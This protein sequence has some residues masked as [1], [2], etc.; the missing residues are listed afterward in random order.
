MAGKDDEFL[1]RLL[2]T[3]RGEAEELVQC[4]S[5]GVMELERGVDDERRRSLVELVYRSAHSLKGAART[6]ELTPLEMLCQ[7]FEDTLA[8]LKAGSI[9]MSAP[10]LDLLHETTDLASDILA[11]PNQGKGKASIQAMRKRLDEAANGKLDGTAAPKSE[12]PQPM[13]TR[14]PATGQTPPAPPME[15]PTPIQKPPQAAIAPR[16]EELNKPASQPPEKISSQSEGRNGRLSGQ[17]SVRISRVKL[18]KLMLQA[19]ELIALKLAVRQHGLA[20]RDI[21]AM[22]SRWKRESVRPGRG[23]TIG[24]AAGASQPPPGS[25][26]QGDASDFIGALEQRLRRLRRDFEDESRLASGMVDS[27][28]SEAKSI[29]LLPAASAIEAFPRLVRDICRADGKDAELA[30][31]GESIEIDRRILQGIR[32]P[33]VHLIRNCLDHGVETPEERLAAG[34]PPRARLQLSFSCADNGK[35]AI[36]LSDDG[37]GIDVE[38]V[39][40]SAIRAGIITAEQAG[41]M[42]RAET[43]PLIFHSGISSSKMITTVSGRGLGM[44]IVK[45]KVEQLGGSLTLQSTPGT[46]TAFRMLLPMSMATFRAILVTAGGRVFAIPTL[47][48]D[49]VARIRNQEVK[50]VENRETIKADGA[51]VALVNLAS[52]LGIPQTVPDEGSSGSVTVLFVGQGDQRIAFAVDEVLREDDVLIKSFGKQLSRVRNISG[53]TVLGNGS[54]I[55]I[56]HVGDLLKSARGAASGSSRP[57]AAHTSTEEQRLHILVADDSITSRTLVKNV[58]ESC[59]YLVTTACDG[60]DALAAL[61]NGKFDLVTSDVEMPRMNGFELTAKI[62]EDEKLKDIPVI[63]ITGLESA[64]DKRRG[65]ES[66]ASAYLVKSSFDQSNLLD[67]LKRLI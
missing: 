60:L 6:V 20:V 62:R 24:T 4:I 29:M 53:A 30:V 50:T 27:F 37:R 59:G 46:G 35:I 65:I 66:G 31:D 55:P 51:P 56:L 13:P 42:T 34:K 39:R 18:D 3:F 48:V 32:D 7:S 12:V 8:A 54:V 19:E 21:T 52:V 64:E 2:D 22:I 11:S 26:W 44:A 57:A 5:D 9:Q 1:K 28:L 16:A 25:D 45:E 33:L 14:T 23:L 67:A 10:L 49:K 40:N 61:Q 38:Q 63:L 17:D 41:G 36:T 58:L 43:I 15:P 47:E